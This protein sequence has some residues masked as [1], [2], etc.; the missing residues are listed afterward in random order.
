[1]TGD[2]F[3]VKGLRTALGWSQEKLAAH[4]CVDRSTVS[5]METSGVAFGPTLVLLKR[6]QSDL[7]SG[8][9]A[10]DAPSAPSSPAEDSGDAS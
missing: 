10:P 1:M 3:D 2:C 7:D 5:R 4:L 8:A 9:I 6:L